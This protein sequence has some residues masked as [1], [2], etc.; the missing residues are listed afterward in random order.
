MSDLNHSVR[1]THGFEPLTV[2]GVVP[3]ELRGTL[4]RAGPGLLQ[5]FGKS[6]HPFLADGAITAVRIDNDAQGA[7]RI[8]ESEKYLEE[9]RCGKALYAP[10]ASLFHRLHNGL[11]GTIKD[12]GNTN[13]LAWQGRLFALMEAGKPVEIDA[14]TIET[15]GSTNLGFIEGAFSAHP[16]RVPALKTTFNF[17]VRGTFID[18]FA[19]P[20]NGKAK[21]LASVKAPW[22]SLI[23]DF[24]MTDKH[25]IFFISPSKLVVW[26]ALLGLKDFSKYFKWD[27]KESTTI[28]VVPLN[29]PEQQYQLE[30]DPFHV[31]HFANA[32]EDGSEIVVDACRHDDIGTLDNPSDAD[33]DTTEPALWRFRINPKRKTFSGESIWESPCEFPM[34]NPSAL[35]TKHRSIWLQTF[36]DENHT[37]GFAR[38]DTETLQENRWFLPNGH[39]GTE[40]L[41]VPRN[42]SEGE[43]WIL[44]LV[45]D[46]NKE[47]SYLAITDTRKM[48]EEPEARIWFNQ[49]I[50]MTFHGVFIPD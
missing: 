18:L 16:H 29:N 9:E 21:R 44:Q 47:R 15:I 30:V 5:R 2:E 3:T 26:R 19:L 8:V 33:A 49:A 23:H 17:G 36:N 22:A 20:D 50:P 45:Q 41:F 37:E 10:N 1:R 32:Y 7:C 14:N 48:A 11:T 28:I 38:I 34:V 25:A 6:V 24:M 4:Y 12:T 31:W 27:A 13:L 46:T 40:P 43:G 39:L 35:G 42:G